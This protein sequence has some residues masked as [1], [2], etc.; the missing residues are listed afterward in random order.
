MDSFEDDNSFQDVVTDDD[1]IPSETSSSASE[2]DLSE[3]QSPRSV[4]QD[5][6]LPVALRKSREEDRKKGQ[7][8]SRQLVRTLVSI[9]SILTPF[10]LGVV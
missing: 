6:K 1:V 2:T 9:L 5:Q 3:P 7:A 8:V 4:D 10:F